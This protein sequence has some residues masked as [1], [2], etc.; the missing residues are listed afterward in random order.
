MEDR[1]RVLQ[2]WHIAIL[3]MSLFVSKICGVS[4]I[5][6]CNMDEKRPDGQQILWMT[7]A[8]PP[9]SSERS[10]PDLNDTL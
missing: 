9:A 1:S 10:L 8:S 7:L 2:F 6:T 5:I 3:T 4:V